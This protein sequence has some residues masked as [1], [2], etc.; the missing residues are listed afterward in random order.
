MYTIAEDNYKGKSNE[1]GASGLEILYY[2]ILKGTISLDSDEVQ[3]L[4]VTMIV[5][6]IDDL[7]GISNLVLG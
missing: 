5:E 1:I 7:H 3:K 4:M 6:E 2:K